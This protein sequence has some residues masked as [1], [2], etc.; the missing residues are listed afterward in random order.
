MRKKIIAGNWKMNKTFQEADELVENISQG[1]KELNL[2]NKEVILCP[3]FLYAEMVS[4]YA[5]EFPFSV[6]MQNVSEYKRGAYTGE[7]SAEMIQSMDINYVI[8]GHSERRSLF[9]ESD[10]VLSSKTDR[11]LAYG[12]TPIFCCGE[13]LEARKK[14]NHFEVVKAQIVEGLFHLDKDEIQKV[15]IAYEPVWA[16]GTGETATKGQAQEMHKFIRKLLAANYNQ[17]IAD[18]I[19]ILYGGSV[20]PTNAEEIFAEPDVDGGLIGGA[21]LIADDFLAIVDAMKE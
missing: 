8:I 5:E 19:T 14:E 17:E 21:S 16:I 12:L 7:V 18:E 20:K 2:N 15:V 13:L 6:G 10:D 1:L 11:A 4:D 9:D 3:P